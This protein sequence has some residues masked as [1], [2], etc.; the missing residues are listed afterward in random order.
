M[1]I[2]NEPFHIMYQIKPY[3]NAFKFFNDIFKECE[4]E[5]I[6]ELFP[7]DVLYSNNAQI[8]RPKYRMIIIFNEYDLISILIKKGSDI[9]IEMKQ[10]T[11]KYISDSLTKEYSL[12]IYEYGRIC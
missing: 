9:P 3:E 5:I 12:A 4:D 2:E 7:A 6:N 8:I 11:Y 10:L 1:L